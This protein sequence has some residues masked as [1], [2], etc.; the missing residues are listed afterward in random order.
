MLL[1]KDGW[2]VNEAGNLT[3]YPVGKMR[4]AMIAED[5]VCLQLGVLKDPQALQTISQFYQV[6]LL[7]QQC[8]DLAEAL[9]REAAKIEAAPRPLAN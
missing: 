1:N 7:P 3:A 6:I 5:G 4:A 8:R 9:L 2:E